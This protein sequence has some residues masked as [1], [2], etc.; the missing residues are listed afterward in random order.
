MEFK[1]M[2]RC[3]E[4]AFAALDFSGLGYVTK[5]SFF[6]SIVIKDRVTFSKEEVELFFKDFNLYGIDS[7]GINY[8]TFK[9][10]FFPQ[11]YLV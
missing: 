11:F 3:C 8:D 6:N 9:K 4:D 10:I 1:K 7:D 5:E 2:Y